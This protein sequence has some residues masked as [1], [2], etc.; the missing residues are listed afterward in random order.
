MNGE[1]II[2]FIG[3]GA[4][5]GFLIAKVVGFFNARNKSGKG[6]EGSMSEDKK[7]RKEESV[8]K[9]T[10][11]DKSLLGF[12]SDDWEEILKEISKTSPQSL[13]NKYKK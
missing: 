3:G 1:L 6:R 11:K 9:E 5:G 7:E 13:S 12:D 10:K 4:I 2:L 8:Q